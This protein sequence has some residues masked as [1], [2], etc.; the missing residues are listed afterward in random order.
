M[1]WPGVRQRAP[2]F[3]TDD[4]VARCVA[5]GGSRLSPLAHLWCSCCWPPRW[6]RRA[7]SSRGGGASAPAP[8]TRRATCPCWCSHSLT[9]V[10]RLTLLTAAR[11]LRASLARVLRPRMRARM[12]RPLPPARRSP[13]TA[14]HTH[15]HT[16][17][18]HRPDARVVSLCLILDQI[19]IHR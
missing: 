1:L 2:G 16:R 8:A 5:A 14:P 17:T 7:R 3:S 15:T 12:P 19:I 13:G 10:D 9:A 6:T 4:G 18:P 11:A